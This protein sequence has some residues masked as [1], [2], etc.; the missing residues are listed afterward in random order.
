VS[1][2]IS[3]WLSRLWVVM[4]NGDHDPND[5]FY[6]DIALNHLA[7]AVVMTGND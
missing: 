6:A 2:E 4:A 3:W 5:S 7:L 1:I